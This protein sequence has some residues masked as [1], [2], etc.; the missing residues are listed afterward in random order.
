[1]S[2][3]LAVLPKLRGLPAE[4]WLPRHRAIVAVIA[5]HAPAL[6]VFA[7]AQG[8]PLWHSAVEAIIPL[9]FAVAAS[10]AKLSQVALSCI[11][12]VG[13]VT[14]SALVT[15]VAEGAIAA[16]FH[17][18]VV[19][20]IIGLYGDWRP[21]VLSVVYVVVHHLG[22]ALLVPDA[23]FP[24]DEGFTR[25]LGTTLVHAGF[26]VAEIV[27]L[28]ASW[29]LAEVQ[30]EVLEA[31]NA[32]LDA[33]QNEL[34]ATVRELEES[35]E[36]RR[37]ALETV[38]AMTGEVR[39]GARTVS[40]SADEIRDT[41]TR[42]TA[43]A[44]QQSA[45]MESANEAVAA[46]AEVAT[47]TAEEA[48][49]VAGEALASLEL[50]EEGAT[51]LREILGSLERIRTEV[52]STAEGVATLS[53]RVRQIGEIT[54]AVDDLSEQS[55]MLALNASIEAA[56]AGEHGRGFAVVAE[57]VRALA[58]R[59]RESTAAVDEILG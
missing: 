55:K 20:P 18:F 35:G 38:T 14:C 34:D 27:A 47:R 54:K 16:H 30:A 40:G 11:A 33:R 36:A 19:L 52:G 10:R 3:V 59:S 51:S 26:V 32:E 22:F 50:T 2:R 1:M 15:H 57:E 53:E 45:A 8:L 13:L 49:D 28:A 24:H 46:A 4:E 48:R 5:L 6:F 37:R 58:E 56:R 44:A 17:F 23:V 9:T 21:F 42:N 41:V 25:T 39:E 43:A 7:L 12:A 29:K 31:R